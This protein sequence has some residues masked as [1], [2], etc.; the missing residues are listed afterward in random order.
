MIA[1]GILAGAAPEWAGGPA[2]GSARLVSIHQVP[3]TGDVCTWE[4]ALPP[5]ENRF[6]ELQPPVSPSSLMASLLPETL[7]AALQQ[8]RPVALTSTVRADRVLT[9]VRTIRD[10]EPTYSAI[11]LDLRND[12]IILQDNN[13]W[14]YRVFN[15]LDNTPPAAK[16]TEPK[17]IVQGDRTDIQFNNGLYIDPKTSEIYSVE[18]DVGDKMVV[19]THDAKGNVPPRRKLHTIHRVYNIAVDE[20]KQELFVTVE[21]PPEV[22]VYPKNAQ[23]EDLPIRRLIGSNTGLNSVH[24]IAIDEKNQLLYVNTWGHYSDFKVAGTGKY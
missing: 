6:S 14:S 15:R 18:S 24:G 12:E 16:F 5:Q 11:G 20:S 7:F 22:D 13:L 19:F 2:T 9:P 17:R 1:I 8:Q 10:L 23:G 3:E 21:F 4:D